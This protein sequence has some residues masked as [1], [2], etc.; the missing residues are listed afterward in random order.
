MK[1]VLS[2]PKE[3]R[4]HNIELDE[5]QTAA[6]VGSRIGEKIAGSKIGLTGYEIKITGG[7][8]RDGTPMKPDVHGAVRTRV[9]MGKGRGYRQRERGV[10]K[11]KLVRGNVVTPEIAQVNAVIVKRGKKAIEELLSK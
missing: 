4:A 8:D 11:R 3:K 6:V 9:L 10:V 2:D 7:S 5:A 1:I